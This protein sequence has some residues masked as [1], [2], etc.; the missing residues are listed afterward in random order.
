MPVPGD[1][2]GDGKTDIGV[3]RPFNGTWYLRYRAWARPRPS[4]GGTDSTCPCPGT[5]TGMGRQTSRCFVR[6]MAPG[7]LVSGMGTTAALQWGNGLDVPVPGD[8]NGDGKTDTAVFRPS[9]GT[10]YLWYS[11]T[12]TTAGVQWGNGSDIPIL[13][14]P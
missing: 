13:K 3:F 6:S 11:G 9:D 8:Y 5:T 14:H 7:T 1:Y 12:V 10:W 4:N 2:N